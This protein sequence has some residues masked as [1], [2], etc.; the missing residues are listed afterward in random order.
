MCSARYIPIY[1]YTG[2]YIEKSLPD[3]RLGWLTP[4]RQIY[5]YIY[6]YIYIL[7]ASGSDPTA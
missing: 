3:V 1:I 6:I 4:A 2:I 7:L 5:I